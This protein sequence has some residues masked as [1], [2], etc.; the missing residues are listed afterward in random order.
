MQ[1]DVPE[2]VKKRRLQELIDLFRSIVAVRNRRFI[3]TDQLVLVEN[4]SK[5]CVCLWSCYALWLIC[6][7]V[8]LFVVFRRA[9]DQIKILLAGQMVTLRWFFLTKKWCV[10]LL[11]RDQKSS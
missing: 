9:N 2:E 1:D 4:V 8:C 10:K 3:G 6:L 7:F 5:V 11:E